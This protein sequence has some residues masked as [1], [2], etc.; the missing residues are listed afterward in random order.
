M[1]STGR[2]GLLI[3]G[4]L[5]ALFASLWFLGPVARASANVEQFCNGYLAAPFGQ[6]GD[7]CAH[8]LNGVT[9]KGVN[10]SAC[11]DALD[12]GGNLIANWACS[13]GPNV[14]V[15]LA[16]CCGRTLRGIVRNNT[17]GDTNHLYGWDLY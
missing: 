11:V 1:R 14:E 15:S 7:R 9:G 6:N 5:V 8:L 2:K 13:S 10:H 12:G 16:T 17:T 4:C 3:A